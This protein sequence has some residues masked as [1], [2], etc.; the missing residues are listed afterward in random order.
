MKYYIILL[1]VS[2]LTFTS[3]SDYLNVEPRSFKGIVG[4]SLL[5]AQ[6]SVN[7]IYSFLRAPYNKYAFASIGFSV[8]EVPT[9]TMKPAEGTQDTGMEQAYALNFDDNNIDARILWQTYFGGIEAANIAIAS[10]PQIED[11]NLTKEIASSLLG[12]AYF[13]R[14]YYYFQLVQIFGEIPMNTVPSTSLD[15]GKLP[16]SSEKDIY[17]Q[18]I[19][20]DLQMAEQAGLPITSRSEGRVSLGAVQ[21]LLAKVYLT[22]AGSPLNQTD[23][24]ALA[25]E[26]AAAVINSGGY[27]LFQDGGGLTWVDKLRNPDFDLQ[28]EHILMA[29]YAA[30][31]PSSFS[32]YFTPIGGTAITDQSL[33]FGGLEPEDDFYNSYDPADMRGMNQGFFF[34]S[35]DGINFNRSVYKYFYDEFRTQRGL[36]TKSFPLIRYADVLLTYAEAQNEAGA[37]NAQAYNALN[38]IR[39]RAGLP[40]VSGL[41]QSDF[42]EEVWRQRTWEF[43]VEG[44]LVWFDMKRTMKVFNGSGFDDFVGATLPSGN[45]LSN[46]NLYF[47]IPA[48]DVLLNPLLGE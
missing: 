22:M 47:P 46:A 45:T 25:A 24:F 14:A 35:F 15:D 6:E 10:I 16:K 30:T 13:L 2:L 18:V 23:K 42:R 1:L 9:G 40:E 32:L 21:A 11:P 27:S 12:E 20:P 39:S 29:Q 31:V 7:G 26:K 36:G 5:D 33:H 44:G 17:E 19:V 43:P 37:A 48:E 38:A 3:C 8:L 28:E 41:S 34:D 4:T